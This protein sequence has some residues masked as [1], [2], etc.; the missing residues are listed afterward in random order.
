MHSISAI[1]EAAPKSS[2]PDHKI[3]CIDAKQGEGEDGLAE[4]EEPIEEDQLQID[5]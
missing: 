1:E 4:V 2:C 5:S 3:P